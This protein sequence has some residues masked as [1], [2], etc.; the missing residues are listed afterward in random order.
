MDS[1]NKGIYRYQSSEGD[2]DEVD[3]DDESEEYE[4]EGDE[5][6]DGEE[7]EKPVAGKQLPTLD[8]PPL[9]RRH[10]RHVCLF[11]SLTPMA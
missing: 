11:A 10:R 7:E 2:E 4:E 6:A 5:G 8:A 9:G 3:E 1:T